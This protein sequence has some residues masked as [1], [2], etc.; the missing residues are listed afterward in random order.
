MSG[1]SGPEG[2]DAPSEVATEVL[3]VGRIGKPRGVRG[4]VFVEPW[5]DAPEERFAVGAVLTADPTEHS[6]LTV[7][8][9]S[10][11]SGRVVVHF[12]GFEDRSG[13]ESLRGVQL[14]IDAADRP[15]LD[16]PDEFYDTDLIG[17]AART[18]AGV[19]LGPV[20]DVLHAAGADYLVLQVDGHERLVPFVGAVVPRVDVAAGV[21]EIDPPDGLFEL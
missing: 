12:A 18:I 6:P 5:T 4:D 19:D 2:S 8:A 16:D 3:A 15:D 20:R 10:I 7:T 9:M 14:L 21:V 1:D 17:L 13:A 11:A